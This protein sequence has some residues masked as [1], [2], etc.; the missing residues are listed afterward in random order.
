M[1]T[2]HRAADEVRTVA[3]MKQRP[4]GINA[5]D[6]PMMQAKQSAALWMGSHLVATKGK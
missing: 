3:L 6:Y 4:Q 5:Q 2:S 1:T